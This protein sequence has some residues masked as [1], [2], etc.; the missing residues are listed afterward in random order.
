M[1]D[2]DEVRQTSHA[3]VDAF[4]EHALVI[5][6]LAQ[7][8]ITAYAADLSAFLAFL[9]ERGGLL[10]TCDEQT[11]LYYL[12][13][14]RTRELSS[15]TLARH[16]A[17]IRGLFHHAFRQGLLLRDPA[18]DLESP[19][20]PKLLPRPLTRNQVAALIEA[21]DVR[22]KLGFRDRTMLELMYA[23]GLRVSELCGLHPLDFD[24]QSGLLRIWGKGAKERIV[25]VHDLAAGLLSDWLESWRPQFRPAEDIVFLNRSGRGLTR[26][27]VWKLVR[28][29]ADQIG[30]TVPISPHTLRHTFATH[31]LEGGADLRS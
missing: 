30:L 13:F 23:A 5:R 19:K 25:P 12:L 27:G 7:D 28:R 17:S 29:Y 22:T 10:E 15:R 18:A 6:G 9:R 21:P 14:Q 31:L 20:L 24:A 1:T 16:L 2:S 8:T 3:W 4:L 26:Q 11:I